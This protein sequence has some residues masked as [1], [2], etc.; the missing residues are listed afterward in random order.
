MS[1][2]FAEK[3]DFLFRTHRRPDRHEYSTR[4]VAAWIQEQRDHAVSPAYIWQLR[5]GERDNPTKRHLED[6]AAFFG[7]SPQY[8][9]EDDETERTQT[10]LALLVALKQQ[11][12][13]QHLALRS[14]GVSAESL[15][16]ISETI[17][18]VRT[19]EGLDR[20]RGRPDNPDDGERKNTGDHEA[21]D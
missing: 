11:P 9:F 15:Q 6:L 13:V 5:S 4:Q 8:F 17:E 18:R 19:L 3:L 14:L 1:Q 7:V 16:A 2:S 10:E 20:Q 21:G 12:E